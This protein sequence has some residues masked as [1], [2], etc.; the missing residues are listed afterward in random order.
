MDDAKIEWL[1]SHIDWKSRVKE[2]TDKNIKGVVF[3]SDGGSRTINFKVRSG[4]GIHAFF[5]NEEKARGIGAYKNEYPTASGYK[6]KK[7]V[8]KEDIVNVFHLLNAYGYIGA[9]TSQVAELEAF[10]QSAQIFLKSGLC[11]F[12]ST[13]SLRTDSE[14]VV[15]GVNIYIDNWA[16]NKWR[17]ADGSSLSNV[18]YWKKIYELMKQFEDLGIGLDVA[19]IKGHATDFGNIIADQMATLGLYQD[20]PYNDEWIAKDVYMA[21]NLE[22]CPLLLESKLLCY[23]QKQNLRDGCFYHFCYNNNN[24]TDDI[25][26]V[27]RNLIDSSISFVATQQ[28]QWQL[29]HLYERCL[30]LDTKYGRY[31]K[32]IDLNVAAKLNLQEEISEENILHLPLE[33]GRK[34]KKLKTTTDKTVITILDPPRNS[35]FTS[36]NLEELLKIYQRLQAGH[37]EIIE[38]DITDHFF[39]K[40]VNGKGVTKYKFNKAEQ[41]SV[42]VVAPIFKESGITDYK[43]E[44]TFGLDLPR[45]RVFS[46]IKD[47]NPVIK[48]FTW[49]ENEHVSYFGTIVQIDNAFGVWTAETSNSVLTGEIKS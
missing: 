28:E 45:R 36:I 40:E 21:G 9:K 6:L 22:L 17:K 31:P 10:I 19:W 1:S 47:C 12:T 42:S 34:D 4:Y 13:F 25:N 32:A 44:L 38:T 39:D 5:Y 27:G 29:A 37:P 16:S 15:N 2:L 18:T 14:Y 20:Q 49:Y 46:N 33:N 30:Q 11:N 35:M 8:E 7:A 24:N 41:M 43:F 3:Y 23:P 26:E 48:I